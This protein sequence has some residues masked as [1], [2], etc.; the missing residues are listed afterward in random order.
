MVWCLVAIRLLIENNAPWML[1]KMKKETYVVDIMTRLTKVL[2]RMLA[3]CKRNI[4]SLS[5]NDQLIRDMIIH[6]GKWI[7]FVTSNFSDSK[8]GQEMS[9]L[10]T[11]LLNLCG[12]YRMESGISNVVEV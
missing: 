12:V 11:N 5:T 9:L 2:F 3:C 8:L 4:H 1:E 7:E 6:I 10:K